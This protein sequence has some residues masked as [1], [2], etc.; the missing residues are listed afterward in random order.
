ME[1]M[2]GGFAG[3]MP[4]FYDPEQ[5]ARWDYRPDVP[6]I[7]HEAEAWRDRY[8]LVPATEMSVRIAVLLVDCQKDFCLPEGSLFVAGRSGRGAVDDSARIA[9][10]LYRNL[11]VITEITPTLD[12]HHPLQIFFDSFWRDAAGDRPPP[13]TEITADDLRNGTWQLDAATAQLALGEVEGSRQRWAERQAR[14]YAEQLERSGKYSLTIWPYH[15]LLGD[16]G[17]S[18]VG[19]IQAAR[20]FHSAARQVQSVPEVKGRLAWTEHYSVFGPEVRGRFDGGPALGVKNQAL[21]DALAANDAVIIA[22]QAASHCVLW[23]IDDLVTALADRD[24]RL[25]SKLF[26]LTDCTS[27]VVVFGPDGTPV[28]DFTDAVSAALARWQDEGVTLVESTTDM[29]A[30]PALGAKVEPLRG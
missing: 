16:P 22:G 1:R 17:H 2:P 8:K 30:W 14:F 3:G 15:C 10:F 6:A 21:I 11:D 9:A 23:S 19:V 4:R 25:V 27:P 7:R 12:S 5:A 20:L 18:M 24:P 13:F 28:V 29:R 26:V